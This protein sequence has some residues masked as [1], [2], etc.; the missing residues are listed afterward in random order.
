MGTASRDGHGRSAGP[1]VPW[2]S[3]DAAP[4]PERLRWLNQRRAESRCDGCPDEATPS[5]NRRTA[6]GDLVRTWSGP[7]PVHDNR[8]S[9][10]A[11][12]RARRHAPLGAAFTTRL[13]LHALRAGT[14]RRPHHKT[15]ARTTNPS[16]DRTL[17]TT[18]AVHPL[19]LI[20]PGHTL[21]SAPPS[22]LGAA[23]THSA[24][25]SR[26]RRRNKTAPTPQNRSPEN[27]QEMRP[28]DSRSSA[29]RPSRKR[30]RPNRKGARPN[31]KR[32]RRPSRKEAAVGQVEHPQNTV[33]PVRFVGNSPAQCVTGRSARI[34]LIELRHVSS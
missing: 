19:H 2:W 10:A 4:R 1:G 27:G 31:R 24:P 32:S 22:R 12:D 9:P 16:P 11:A 29:R 18:T 21:H 20:V 7:D 5:P 26:T 17:S 30:A 3:P 25:P 34:G 6:A 8:Y 15:G 28:R 14:R 13:R 23:F 33:W